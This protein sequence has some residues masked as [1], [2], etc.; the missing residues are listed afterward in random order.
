MKQYVSLNV[1]SPHQQGILHLHF[2]DTF[3]SFCQGMC[4]RVDCLRGVRRKGCPF[5]LVLRISDLVSHKV[6]ALFWLGDGATRLR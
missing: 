1:S 5:V 3:Q 6:Q 2:V 4:S